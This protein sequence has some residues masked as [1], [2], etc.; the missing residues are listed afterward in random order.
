MNFSG[1]FGTLLVFADAVF[2]LI[3]NSGYS[4]GRIFTKCTLHFSNL[5]SSHYNR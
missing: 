5:D 2:T 4:G 3:M 1:W